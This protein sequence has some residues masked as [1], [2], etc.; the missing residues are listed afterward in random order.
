VTPPSRMKSAERTN[1]LVVDEL[2]ALVGGTM[3]CSK[4]GL[5]ADLLFCALPIAPEAGVCTAWSCRA[6]TWFASPTKRARRG[7]SAFES[8]GSLRQ[9]R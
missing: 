2:A 1:A 5:G 8:V 9:G 4:T 3:Y 7:V 6:D